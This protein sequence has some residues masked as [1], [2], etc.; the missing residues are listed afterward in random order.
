MPQF[1]ITDV[2]FFSYPEEFRSWLKENHLLKKELWVGF[3]KKETGKS[4]L[5]WSQSVDE[6]LCF[7]WIDGIRKSIDSQSYT[8]RFTPRNPKSI[9][10]AVNIN[11][12][13]ELKKSGLM[14]PAGLKAFEHRTDKNSAIYSFEQ[15]S[16]QLNDE[17]KLAF[18]K[19]TKAW[20]FFISQPPSYQKTATWWVISARQETTRRKRMET[21]MEDSENC[22]RIAPLRRNQKQ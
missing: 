1:N 11:K 8:I 7:G 22:L 20:E 9:W 3:Y 4:S 15:Q 14:N 13:E 6:A 21:L 2:L 5:T 18:R 19:N 16:A 10:S 12:V 17:F